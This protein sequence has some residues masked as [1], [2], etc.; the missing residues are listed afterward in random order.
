[1]LRASVDAPVEIKTQS[2]QSLQWTRYSE[3]KRKDPKVVRLL[4]NCTSNDC[5][6]V[7]FS[8]LCV[9]NCDYVLERKFWHGPLDW[10]KMNR[11]WSKT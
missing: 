9:K 1:M 5:G 7:M 2:L 4:G 10:G 8:R 3:R 11:D 6:V